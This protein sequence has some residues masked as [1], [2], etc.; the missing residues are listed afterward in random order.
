MLR[1]DLDPAWLDEQGVA[2]L[3]YSRLAAAGTEAPP[4]LRERA[5]RAAVTEPF[6]L[7]DLRQV[8]A[9]LAGAGVVPLVV[10]GSALA[11]RIYPAPELRPRGDSDLLI[12]HAELP[13]VRRAL[14]PLGFEERV[15]PG[16]E[17]TYRQTTF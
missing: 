5:L 3:Q 13:A 9:A 14:A 16:P 12:D 1:A 8:L 2:P 7:A 15:A 6:R 4:G 10:K 11:Y 17:A